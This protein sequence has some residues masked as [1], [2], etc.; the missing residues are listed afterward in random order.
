[1]KE[2]KQNIGWIQLITV[3]ENAKKVNERI[4]KRNK[5]DAIEIFNTLLLINIETIVDTKI[6]KHPILINKGIKPYFV[7]T[8]LLT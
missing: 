1:M 6:I 4:V 2:I 5:N 8:T 7:K 3:F